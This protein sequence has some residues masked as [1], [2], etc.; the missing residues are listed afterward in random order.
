M[1][2][3]DNCPQFVHKFFW[4]VYIS[5]AWEDPFLVREQTC[6]CGYKMDKGCAKRLAFDLWIQAN[7][8][9][10]NTA[11]QCRLG[12][13]QDSDFAGDSEDSK[14]TSGGILCVFGSHT[15]VPKSWMYKKQ[16]SV[17]HSSTEA[18][19]ISLDAGLRMDGIRAL[20]LWD[21]VLE[22]FLS[23]PNHTNKTNYAREP[24]RN[25][26]VNTQP[27]V[28]NNNHAHQSR[29]D[30]HWKTFH[31]TEHILVPMLCCMS[32]KTM[33]PWFLW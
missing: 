30:Q 15:F 31:Q 13:I 28:Q 11:Q 8:F 4:N 20:D 14:S 17:S 19:V 29:S 2:Q 10:G 23:T 5:I 24:R 6:S 1:D 33:K 18:E 25:L 26:S 3:L 9:V 7:C 12:L 16:T 22:V 27:N 32:L 21:L